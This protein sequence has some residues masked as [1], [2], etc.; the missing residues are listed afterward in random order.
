MM[1]TNSEIISLTHQLDRLKKMIKGSKYNDDV[2]VIGKLYKFRR[3]IK[4]VIKN[5][6]KEWIIKKERLIYELMLEVR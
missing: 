1:T 4:E 3:V 6:T 2:K 5:V